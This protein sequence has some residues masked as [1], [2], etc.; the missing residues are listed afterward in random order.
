MEE[1]IEMKIKKKEKINSYQLI[2]YDVF[3]LMLTAN[4]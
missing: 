2:V 4:C 1:I 3:K